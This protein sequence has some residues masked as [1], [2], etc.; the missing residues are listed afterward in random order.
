MAIYIAKAKVGEH[1]QTR[2]VEAKNEAQALRHLTEQ[3]ITLELVKGAEKMKSMAA[4]AA[5]GVE[6]EQASE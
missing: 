6:V 2:L 5:K 3:H 1:E 4:L